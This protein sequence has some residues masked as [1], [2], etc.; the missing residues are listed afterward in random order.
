M[1]VNTGDC[2]RS[3]QFAGHLFQILGRVHVAGEATPD[4][5]HF[6]HQVAID[7]GSHAKGV[8]PRRA[9]IAL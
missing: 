8:Q 4:P 6:A 5:A 1:S 2:R 7:P 3:G 9:E